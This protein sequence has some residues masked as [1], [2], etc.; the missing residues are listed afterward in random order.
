MTHIKR[1]KISN[2]WISGDLS[3]TGQNA[4]AFPWRFFAFVSIL[5]LP[6]GDLFINSGS[7]T[8]LASIASRPAPLIFIIV[9][10]IMLSTSG[11]LL[12]SGLLD[13]RIHMDSCLRPLM[14]TNNFN[15]AKK[16]PNRWVGG[17]RPRWARAE[18]MRRVLSTE[19]I[20]DEPNYHGSVLR[21]NTDPKQ[22]SVKVF[23]RHSL[24]DN[25]PTSALKL[26]V[27]VHDFATNHIVASNLRRFLHKIGFRQPR[28]DSD[29]GHH[30]TIVVH[31]FV[32][33]GGVTSSERVDEQKEIIGAQVTTFNSFLIK[34]NLHVD[35]CVLIGAGADTVSMEL[36]GLFQAPLKFPEQADST[37]G[38]YLLLLGSALGKSLGEEVFLQTGLRVKNA[39]MRYAKTLKE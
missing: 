25:S 39:L 11:L 35:D 32:F 6:V 34:N 2:V 24:S 8:V 28:S 21:I 4:S 30:S 23:P 17:R 5:F 31:I 14:A 27:A 3:E 38:D 26:F 9:M 16:A 1:I 19:S 22:K 29:Y 36:P 7:G 18:E 12:L 13:R 20:D 33:G 10:L 37:L 15:P